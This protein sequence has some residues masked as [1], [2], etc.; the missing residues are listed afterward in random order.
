MLTT[1]F[2]G[3]IVVKSWSRCISRLDFYI[4]RF[5]SYI[6]RLDFYEVFDCLTTSLWVPFKARCIF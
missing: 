4:S 5:D 3:P 2:E 1:Q 6:S